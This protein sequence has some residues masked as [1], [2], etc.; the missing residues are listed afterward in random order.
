[1]SSPYFNAQKGVATE[2]ALYD[3]MIT[4]SIEITGV[5]VYYIPRTLSSSLD[6]IFPILN[7]N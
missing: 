2:H 6:Q 5:D 3:S 1:M 4:E 7:N